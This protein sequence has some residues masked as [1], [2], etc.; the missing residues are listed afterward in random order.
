MSKKKNFGFGTLT[1][2]EKIAV[3]KIRSQICL[4]MQTQKELIGFNDFEEEVRALAKHAVNL[5]MEHV[6]KDKAMENPERFES[7]VKL[8]LSDI[9]KKLIKGLAA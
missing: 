1:E 3:N 5:C 8:V 7:F 9:L 4:L 6:G 2:T